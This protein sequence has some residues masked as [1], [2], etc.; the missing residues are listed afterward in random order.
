MHICIHC[1]G[2]LKGY[3]VCP[4]HP[5]ATGNL[6]AWSHTNRCELPDT[7]GVFKPSSLCGVVM[8]WYS[9]G[10]CLTPYNCQ[11]EGSIPFPTLYQWLCQ[12]SDM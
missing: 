11:A 8:S 2:G 6:P 1:D 4:L 12:K 5:L 7:E 9:S 3:A 10:G